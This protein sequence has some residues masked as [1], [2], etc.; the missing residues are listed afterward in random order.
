V[1]RNHKKNAFSGVKK[2]P[3]EKKER[4]GRQSQIAREHQTIRT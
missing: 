4:E 2:Q 1:E 3:K